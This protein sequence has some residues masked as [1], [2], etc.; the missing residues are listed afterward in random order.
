MSETR[1]LR[2]VGRALAVPVLAAGLITASPALAHAAT[3]TVITTNGDQLAIRSGPNLSS[4]IIGWLP[5]GSSVSFSCFDYGDWVTGP[6]GS[7]NI[8]DRLDSGGYSSDAWI[9]T[10]SNGSVVPQCGSTPPPPPPPPAANTYPIAWTGIGVYPRSAPYMGSTKIGNALP[11]GTAVNIACETYGE[12]VTDTVGYT[13]NI[14]ERLVDGTY[15][16]NVFVNTGVNGLTPG[17]PICASAPAPS[18]KFNRNAASA[19]ALQHARDAQPFSAACTW[20][21]SNV[22]WAGGMPKTATW[23]SAGSYGTLPWNHRPGT[24][25]ANAVNLLYPYLLTQ[26]W[27]SKS[28]NLD[29]GAKVVPGAAPGDLIVY[30]WDSGASWDH[31]AVVSSTSVGGTFVSEWGSNN[32]LVT[33]LGGHPK[34]PYTDRLWN[35]SAINQTTLISST[36]GKVRAFLIHITY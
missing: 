31:I 17:I 32:N 21:A 18:Q 9:Y 20:F 19:W 14:W 22:L 29:F 10:G 15:V 34:S 7:E 24:P 3:G 5:Q 2:R 12:T 11:D 4:S 27:A 36:G 28:G 16:A 26:G 33:P 1:V 6:Y 25:T 13:N 35:Y 23:T 30:S 8:W